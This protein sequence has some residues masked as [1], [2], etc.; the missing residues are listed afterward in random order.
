M[1]DSSL[2]A[3]GRGTAFRAVAVIIMLI[4]VGM[5]VGLFLTGTPLG[6]VCGTLDPR[7]VLM[8]WAICLGMSLLLC[9]VAGYYASRR[10]TL[11]GGALSYSTWFSR[12]TVAV[13]R[14]TH[15]TLQKEAVGADQ[16]G[17]EEFLAL[18]IDGERVIRLNL[19]GWDREALRRVLGAARAI[20]PR[21]SVAPEVQELF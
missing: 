11:A 12:T 6:E 4:A 14:M 17:E 1:D 10:L 21:L 8:I 7:N 19:R 18:W 20:N 15:A 3:R 5:P 13:D 2:T 16:V 9:V